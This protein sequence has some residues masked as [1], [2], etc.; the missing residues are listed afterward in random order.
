LLLV[1]AE[2]VGA[3]REVLDVGAAITDDAWTGE[4]DGG[5]DSGDA[6]SRADSPGTPVPLESEAGGET[7][8]PELVPVLQPH[9]ADVPPAAWLLCSAPDPAPPAPL[10]LFEQALQ[11]R[12]TQLVVTELAEGA[13]GAGEKWLEVFTWIAAQKG[14]NRTQS[15]AFP[16]FL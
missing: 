8:P 4:S 13:E 7:A 14:V 1:A 16:L 3:A 10:A 15:R 5:G 6:N 9:E 12:M 2:D 11:L